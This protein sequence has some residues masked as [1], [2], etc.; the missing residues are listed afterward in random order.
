MK[1][2]LKELFEGQTRTKVEFNSL[3]EVKAHLKDND[4]FSWINENEPKKELPS[5]ED[6]ETVREIK[7]IF[8]AYDYDYWTMEL[9]EIK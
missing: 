7:A 2:L 9:K 8:K 5:F 4:Y 3:E 6:V 1:Y